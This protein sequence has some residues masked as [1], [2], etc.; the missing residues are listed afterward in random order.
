MARTG[1][2]RILAAALVL[3]SVTFAAGQAD[4]GKGNQV[5]V[6]GR[7]VEGQTLRISTSLDPI[8]GYGWQRCTPP[9]PCDGT[10]PDDPE[11]VDIQ[12]AVTERY[13]LTRPDVGSYVRG[14]VY[15][16]TNRPIVSRLGKGGFPFASDRVGPIQPAPPPPPPGELP[17]PV[18]HETANLEPV[19]GEVFVKLP[20]E[21][22]FRPLREAEQVPLGSLIDATHGEVKVITAADEQGTVQTGWF[23]AGAFRLAQTDGAKPLTELKLSGPFANASGARIAASE[24]RRG[25]DRRLWGRG[26]CK[27]RTE[28]RHSSGT[29]RGTKW[30]TIDSRRKTV[31]KVKRGKVRVRDFKAHRTITVKAG[32][33]YTAGPG[34]GRD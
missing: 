27:C 25:G 17:P 9:L 8:L 28:G 30:L 18:A 15:S 13:V 20:G 14:L 32:E 4:A 33:S 1:S 34:G 26:R 24:R 7:A 31:T 5:A 2:R 19:S 16:T 21:A 11:W 22:N 29:S 23:W 6:S 12:G 10:D 3:A